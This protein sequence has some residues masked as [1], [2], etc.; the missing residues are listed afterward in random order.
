M[1]TPKVSVNLPTLEG[2]LRKD[3]GKVTDA[4]RAAEDS[5]VDSIS[6]P[7]FLVGDATPALESV[8]VLAAAAGA[9][10][11]V[12]L[13]FGVIAL[14]TRPV[15]MLAAQVQ[16]LQHLSG[17]RVRL[18]VGIGGAPGSPFWKAVGAPTTHRGRLADT[19]LTLLP[20]LIRG[21]PTAVPGPDGDVEVTLAPGA[22]APPL[23]VGGGDGDA[24]LR[25]AA[26]FGHAWVPSAMTTGQVAAAAVRLGEIAAE[27]G[28]PA[29]EIHLGAHT[30]LG[31]AATRSAREAMYAELGEFF[32]MTPDEVA[33]VTIVGGPD[34]VA[35]RMAAYAEAG[36]ASLGLAVDG[37]DYRGGLDVIAEARALL[38]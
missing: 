25:R 32:E 30:L 12:H 34:E 13:D 8:T 36:V 27:L 28:R 20:P 37:D 11:R 1:P 17:N 2:D 10:H 15:A 33:E 5:G 6:A 26:A 9:T 21:E 14:P 23:L 22:P 38:T 35:E 7:D 18:G 29:P 24:P 19:A 4:A 31:R 16:T 3:P